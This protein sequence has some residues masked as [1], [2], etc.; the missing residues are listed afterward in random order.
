MTDQN[1]IVALLRRTALFPAL[2]ERELERVASDPRVSVARYHVGESVYNVQCFRN[3]LGAVLS[4]R[5]AICRAGN[6]SRVLLNRLGE[7]GLFGAAS[8]FGASD[9]YV[10]EITA[11]AEAEIVFL[12]DRLCEELISSNGDFAVSYIRFLSDRIRFLNRR[13]AEL[14]ASGAERRFA[15]YLSECGENPSPNMKQL[16]SF[17]GIGR[18]SLYRIIDSFTESGLIEK[19]GKVLVI[20]DPEGLKKLI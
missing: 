8:L 11:E 5:V 14:S 7:G 19:N 1:R 12:P 2:P 3:A 13:I 18:A 6:G 10:T 17:L 15:K 16:A 4:G 20:K 9:E